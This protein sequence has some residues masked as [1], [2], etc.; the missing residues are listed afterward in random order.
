MNS[1]FN[2]LKKQVIITISTFI[3]FSIFAFIIWLSNK[4]NEYES[5]GFFIAIIAGYLLSILLSM[6]L[7]AARFSK[8]KNELPIGL[9]NVIGVFDICI[10]IVGCG[11][12]YFDNRNS[13][14][15]QMLP[16][17]LS[18]LIALFIFEDIYINKVEG[19]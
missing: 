11:F 17:L 9:Y 8:R 7:I 10:S 12:I 5:L 4:H 2:K 3:G 16:F 13:I 6:M 15:W 19:E 18:F 14:L 1:T